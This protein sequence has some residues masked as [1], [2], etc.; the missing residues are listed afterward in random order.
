ISGG[1]S[2]DVKN[3]SDVQCDGGS[4]ET[5]VSGG[6]GLYLWS[7]GRFTVRTSFTVDG[8]GTQV[9]QGELT[10]GGL[11]YSFITY[12]GIRGSGDLYVDRGGIVRVGGGIGLT[13]T[14]I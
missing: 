3:G 12:P 2:W 8:N 6:P 5:S 9:R 7:G 10:V 11:F 1:R 13:N 14:N 4:I